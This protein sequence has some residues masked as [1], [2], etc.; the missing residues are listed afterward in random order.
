MIVEQPLTLLLTKRGGWK[1]QENECLK[2]SIHFFDF[3]LFI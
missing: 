2:F 3:Y 1:G